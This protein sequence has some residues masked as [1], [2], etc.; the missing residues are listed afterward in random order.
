M[1]TTTEILSV[2]LRTLFSRLFPCILFSSCCQRVCFIYNYCI[3]DRI[4]TVLIIYACY[5]R[6]LFVRVVSAVEFCQIKKKY[7]H[8][9]VNGCFLS[10]FAVS[11]MCI[12]PDGSPALSTN[13]SKLSKHYQQL[14]ESVYMHIHRFIWYWYTSLIFPITRRFGGLSDTLRSH[15]VIKFSNEVLRRFYVI[16]N[17]SDSTRER[18]S[19][20]EV[21]RC[22]SD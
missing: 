20:R 10:S 4:L 16:N 17:T 13:S 14:F 18:V 19:S 11:L 12:N 7:V 22:I 2:V 9:R 3:V 15:R 6:K 8:A 1:W 21:D 5:T